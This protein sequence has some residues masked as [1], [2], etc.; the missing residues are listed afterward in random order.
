MN[1]VFAVVVTVLNFVIEFFFILAAEREKNQTVTEMNRVLIGKIGMFQ[2]IFAGIFV[3]I[4]KQFVHILFSSLFNGIV[5][6]ITLIMILNALIPNLLLIIVNYCQIIKKIK[7]RL[8]KKDILK[9]SQ[10][11]ANLLYEGPPT[12]IPEKYI[13]IIR[14][15][16]LSAFY[17]PLVPIVV[18]ISIIG[19][20]INYFL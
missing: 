12:R 7:R 13:Y 9:Y 17:A 11:E 1:V 14:T 16:W 3:L 15:I 19:L 4:V 6:Q 18:P 10:Y 8:L 5:F 20:I 2:F